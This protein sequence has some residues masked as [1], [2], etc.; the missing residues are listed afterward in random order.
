MIPPLDFYSFICIPPYGANKTDP[1]TW[2]LVAESDARVI[3]RR[4]NVAIFLYW[5]VGCGRAVWVYLNLANGTFLPN[6]LI[7][8]G[9]Y[10]AVLTHVIP[11]IS[12]YLKFLRA[13]VILARC[14]PIGETN[15][16][17]NYIWITRI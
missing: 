8:A 6:R 12:K 10:L 7:F 16:S 11:V 14:D 13:E 1:S 5:S 9:L 17:T 15:K 2:R 4:K 3:P